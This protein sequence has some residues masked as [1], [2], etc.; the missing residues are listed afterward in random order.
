MACVRVPR[1]V[2]LRGMLCRCGPHVLFQKAAP[3]ASSVPT[4]P[5]TLTFSPYSMHQID[6]L[7]PLFV[8]VNA[9]P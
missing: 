8:Y 6:L 4:Q 5:T 7:C 2:R 9:F 3:V 1:A